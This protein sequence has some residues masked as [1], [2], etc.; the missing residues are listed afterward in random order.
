VTALSYAQLRAAHRPESVRVLLIG[1]SAPNPGDGELRFFYAPTLDRRDNLFRGIVAA[2]YDA[3][4]GRAGDP[5]APWLERLKSDR[6]FLIDLVRDPVDKLD[7]QARAKALRDHVASCVD[8]V[9]AIAPTGIIVCHKPTFLAVSG[10]LRDARLPLLHDEPIPFPLAHLRRSS[11]ACAQRC[12]TCRIAQISSRLDRRTGQLRKKSRSS[13][14]RSKLDQWKQ[15]T[16]AQRS[17]RDSPPLAKTSG[18]S[19]IRFGDAELTSASPNLRTMSWCSPTTRCLVRV[20]SGP[21]SK[22]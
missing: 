15:S 11:Q 5:K 3:K 22:H 12:S 1:E 20:S 18:A 9:R 13:I 21:A 2:L 16:V 6:V 4:P 19:M 7:R 8:E 14:T 17:T 10:P